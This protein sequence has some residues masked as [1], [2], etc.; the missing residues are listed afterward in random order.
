MDP[1]EELRKAVCAVDPDCVTLIDEDDDGIRK[2]SP[3]AATFNRKSL[4]LDS[5]ARQ[6]AEVITASGRERVMQCLQGRVV[7]VGTVCS[8]CDFIRPLLERVARHLNDVII[9]LDFSF[10]FLFAC[11]SSRICREWI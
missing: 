6:I 9:G 1:L 8:G 10:R 3:A 7:T 11:D 4:T 2:P 5:R